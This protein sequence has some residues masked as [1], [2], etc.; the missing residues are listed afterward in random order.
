MVI[1]ALLVTFA[2]P[3]TG[4][5]PKAFLSPQKILERW[6]ASYGKL[7]SMRVSYCERIIRAVPPASDPNI[8]RT[9]V[10]WHHEEFTEDSGRFRVRNSTA[11]DGFSNLD[12]V[13]ETSFDG[14]HQRVYLPGQK[15][16]RIYAGVEK[17][18]INH[19][20]RYLLLDPRRTCSSPV[21]QT[22]TFSKIVSQGISEP[23]FAISV[24]PT[25][26]G[27]SGQ[28]C[29]V[30][31]QV[32]NNKGTDSS[33]VAIVWVAHEKGMIPMKFQE[34][35]G[36][37]AITHEITVEQI[38]FAG[39]GDTGLWYPKKASLTIN[40]P[41]YL[42]VI[43]YQFDVFSFVPNIQPPLDTFQLAFPPGTHVLD[44]ELGLQY[45]VGVE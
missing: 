13:V 25:L 16:G 35:D 29:H 8:I 31:E 9:L 14:I 3:A 24:R 28:M 38:A 18:V 30:I 19:L 27:V 20:K 37:G 26:E 7:A 22:P 11:E 1:L 36:N 15:Q 34:F 2:L 42:G 17:T 45:V 12:S 40:L 4:Q 41:A 32:W 5:Q 21:D 10:Q 44:R 39:T 23:N 6:Q 43:K 33:V